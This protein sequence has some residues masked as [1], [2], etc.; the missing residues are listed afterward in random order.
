MTST[1]L[2]T[3]GPYDVLPICAGLS[4]PQDQ[5]NVAAFENQRDLWLQQFN[6]RFEEQESVSGLTFLQEQIYSFCN[7]YPV[8]DNEGR[9]SVK[10]Y[11]PPMPNQIAPVINDNEM[12][13]APRYQSSRLAT[14]FYN[15][16]D[17]KYDWDFLTQTFTSRAF[18]EDL[19]S[20]QT[21]D[22]VSTKK[23][24]SRGMRGGIGA[25]GTPRIQNWSVRFLK[26]FSVPPPSVQGTFL[27]KNR[28]LEP[29]DIV[30]ITSIHIPNLSTGKK[31]VVTKLMELVEYAPDAAQGLQSAMLLDTGYS[32]GRKYG[33][34]SPSAQPPIN[35]PVYSAATP[36]QRNYAFAS[37]K[38]NAT[39]GVMGNGDDGYYVSP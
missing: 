5:V 34:I 9:L 7:S 39:T 13:G 10:V 1:G 21:Y 23:L 17:L 33:A 20:Q 29:G 12:A 27:Y 8:I 11:T 2:G 31:G 19:V 25:T 28:L 38:I 36:A 22:T 4:I 6:F 3:N 37:T 26:R 18:F 32:Y 16:I 30:P 14:T 24:E 15:E 35:F